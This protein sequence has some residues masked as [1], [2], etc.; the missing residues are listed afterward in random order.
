MKKFSPEENKRIADAVARAESATAG[1]IVIAVIPESDNYAARE[2][3][4]AAGAGTL[5]FIAALFFS[6]GIE[7]AVERWFW[8]DFPMLLP[9]AMGI[10]GM[11]AALVVYFLIQIPFLD[12]LVIGKTAMEEAVSRRAMRH[13]TESAVYDTV[14]RTGVL[15][16]I[17]LLERRVELIADRGIN[18]LVPPGTWEGIVSSLTEGIKEKSLIMPLEKAV[19]EIGEVLA[20]HVPPRPD[21]VNEKPDTPVHLQR[22]S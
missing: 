7:R 15:L 20:G 11:A 10:L 19:G 21:D 2:M 8:L 1:E 3:L 14:D 5:V 9:A 18:S 4:A 12:R 13:F 16:F 17:S 22:G 6:A